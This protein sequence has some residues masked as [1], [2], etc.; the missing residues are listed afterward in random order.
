MG[1]ISRSRLARSASSWYL[2][3]DARESDSPKTGLGPGR[4]ELRGE[5]WRHV[6]PAPDATQVQG[7]LVIA[8]ER[9]EGILIRPAVAV[10]VEIYSPARVAEFLLSNA[11]NARD[12]RKAVLAVRKFGINPRTI[13][14]H[15]PPAR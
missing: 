6:V 7:S 4:D 8:E 1:S 13:A 11:V 9:G 15:R 5:A 14:H 3:L 10:P 12:Y 2:G